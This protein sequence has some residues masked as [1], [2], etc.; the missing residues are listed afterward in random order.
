MLLDVRGV[1]NS[2]LA[3]LIELMGLRTGWII[4][5]DPAAQDGGYVLAAHHHL[6]PALEADNADAWGMACTC[7]DLCNQGKLTQAYNEVRCSRLATVPGDRRG[8]AVHASTPLRS[9]DRVLGILNVAAPDWSSFSPQALALLSDVG[10]QMGVALERARLFD[11]LQEQR[12]HEQSVLLD[13]SNQLLSHPDLDDLMDYLV[14]EVQRLL[15]ADA[16]ALLLPGEEPGFFD[17]RAVRGWLGNPLAERQRIPGNGRHGLGLALHDQRPW[18]V[19]D[20]EESG[21]ASAVPGWLRAEG[22]R[23]HAVMPLIAEGHPVGALM[24]NMRQP[25]LLDEDEVRLLRL[26]ANQSAIAIETACLRQEEVEREQLE[27]E[28]ALGRQIQLSLLPATSPDIPGWEYA[29]FYP[30]AHQVGGDF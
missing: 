24:I 17:V 20:L 22:F 1:L 11:R 6:P 25:R 12:L 27:K 15:G 4:L 28:L 18:L 26:M 29:S 23:G 10:S 19:E 21:M 8:L 30:A 16:C 13:F 2:A 3:R 5:K 9:G 14:E 7:Q